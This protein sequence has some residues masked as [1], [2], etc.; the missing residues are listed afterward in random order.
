[1]KNSE[2]K[3]V[4]KTRTPTIKSKREIKKSVN[5]TWNSKMFFQ[6][7]I[8]IALSFVLLMVETSWGISSNE[9]SMSKELNIDEPPLDL[10]VL[11][12]KPVIK[13]RIEPIKTKKSNKVDISKG[14]KVVGNHTKNKETD[15][16]PTEYNNPK[17]NTAVNNVHK[18][19]NVMNVEFAPIFPG[20]ESLPTN[21]EKVSCMS[22]KIG[23]FINRKFR[24]ERFVEREICMD[25]KEYLFNL[26]LMH[27]GMSQ[28]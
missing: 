21:K 6:I 19:L 11:E 9:I 18:K 8:I 1:M 22:E 4:K 20:C 16:R 10:Y 13:K 2:E 23:A 15:T 3:I 17:K 25:F 12:E 7:G 24:V 26:K 14:L 5:I 28:M 27:G